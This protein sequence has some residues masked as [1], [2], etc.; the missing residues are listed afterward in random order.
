[1]G[2]L[3]EVCLQ[4]QFISSVYTHKLPKSLHH[5][6]FLTDRTIKDL[7]IAQ[8]VQLGTLDYHS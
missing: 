7:A 6:D 8:G 4:I 1:M 2:K 3:T 5:L